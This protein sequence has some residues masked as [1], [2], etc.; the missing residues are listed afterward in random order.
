MIELY[1]ENAWGSKLFCR[2][3]TGREN[4]RITASLMKNIKEEN[5]G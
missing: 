1:A 2:R 4:A 5:Y 3:Y